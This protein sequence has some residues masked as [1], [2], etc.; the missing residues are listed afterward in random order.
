[1]GNAR[2]ALIVATSKYRDTRLPPLEAP[3]QDAGAL[4]RVLGNDGI[5]GFTVRLALDYR[6]QTLRKTLET[7]FARRSRDDLLLVHFSCH[8]L[9]DDEGQLY[10]AAADTEV[11]LLRATALDTEWLRQLMNDCRSEK[12]A[13]FLDCCFGGAFATN[14]TQRVGV[15]TPGIK[16]HLGGSGRVVIT[17]SNAVQYAFEGGTRVGTPQPSAFTRALVDGLDTGEA[18]RNQD[19]NVTINELFEYLADKVHETSPA[20]TPTKWEFNA[21]G[22]WVIA[23]SQRTPRAS[24]QLL[25]A[26]LQTLLTSPDTVHRLAA[27]TELRVL[28]EAADATVVES[29]RLAA[30]QLASDDS[31]K[32][33]VAATHL[34]DE[35]PVPPQTGEAVPTPELIEAEAARLAAERAEAEQAEAERLA[36]ERLAA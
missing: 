32:V 35:L 14:M 7:F 8:G 29:A 5:G 6:V 2:N 15:D 4:R 13:V 1:M 33:S 23:R 31:R 20:Q 17:A 3:G 10:L 24:I 16:E 12:I 27:L 21:A 11:D 36:A 30:Q 34:L 22:D 28:L 25:P 9:K 18:D 19:G 26:D